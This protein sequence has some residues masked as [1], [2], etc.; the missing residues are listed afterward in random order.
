MIDHP[1][2]L[3]LRNQA[4]AM[5]DITFSTGRV[6]NIVRSTV[7]QHWEL[8]SVTFPSVVIKDPLPRERKRV[9]MND[10]RSQGVDER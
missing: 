7:A 8:G 2:N 9:T 4:S 3:E 10:A 5:F 6:R 1:R